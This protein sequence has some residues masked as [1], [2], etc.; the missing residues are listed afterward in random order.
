MKE[1]KIEAPKGKVI[2]Q[3]ETQDGL[4]IKFVDEW[5]P[6]DGDIVYSGGYSEG[7]IIIVKNINFQK[8]VYYHAAITLEDRKLCLPEDETR[9]VGFLSE[10][11]RPATSEEQQILFDSLKEKGKRWNSEKKCIEDIEQALLVPEEINIIRSGNKPCI[12]NGDQALYYSIYGNWSV[13]VLDRTESFPNK[14]KYKLVKCEWDDL[15]VGDIF[16]CSDFGFKRI[17]ELDRYKIKLDD[18]L[19]AYWCDSSVTVRNFPWK[20]YYKVVP[21]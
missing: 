16:Y 21:I 7:W 5:V 3:E 1:I 10:I 18:E 11:E 8:K 9:Y 20:H 4:I 14:L 6:K 2:Q 12:V 13:Y 15:K 19:Y 17:G